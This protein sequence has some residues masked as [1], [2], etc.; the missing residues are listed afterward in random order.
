M[1]E[2]HLTFAPADHQRLAQLLDRTSQAFVRIDPEQRIVHVNRA[3]EK[4]LGYPPGALDGMTI[5]S[6]TPGIWR[7]STHNAIER[8]QATG[9]PQRYEKEYTHLDGHAVPV[10][11]IADFD[12]DDQEHVRGYYAFATDISE[13]KRIEDA[14]VA[15]E[16]RLRV[17]FEGISDAVFVH[18][19]EGRILDVNPAASRMLGYSRDEFRQLNTRD[20]DAPE[21]AEGFEERLRT[22]LRL[23][24][25]WCEG[26][27]RTR[28]GRI[29]PVEINTST[30]QL[31]NRTA[32]LA[33]IRD[34]S[35]RKNLEET[36]LRFAESQQQYA[37]Q[38]ETKAAELARS[39][40]HHRQ[41]TESLLDA[42]VVTDADA[43]ITLFNRAAEAV[44]GYDAQAVLGQPLEL[45][46]PKD[47]M[48]CPV[49]DLPQTLRESDPKVVGHT[50]EIQ[51]RRQSGEPVPLEISVAVIDLESNREFVASIRDLTERHRM[52]AM[53]L[54]SEKLASIG[55]LSA[56][57]AHEINNPL[58]YVANNLAVLQRDVGSLI[59]MVDALETAAVAP[60][61]EAQAAALHDAHRAA[62]D[63]DWPYVREH[64]PP[65]IQRTREGVQRVADIVANLRGLARTGPTRFELL[66]LSDLIDTALEMAQS[67][68][69][70]SNIEVRLD[71]PDLPKIPGV[72]AQISQVFLNFLVNAVQAIEQT[73]R[74]ID[75]RITIRLSEVG[76]FQVF[77]IEDNGVGI[78]PDAL[79][80][81]FDPFYTTKPV[82]EGTGLGLAI[83]HGI[84]TGHGG[85][86]QVESRAGQG[87][88]FRVLLPNT[89]PNLAA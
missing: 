73:K 66:S 16:R 84:I 41:L 57:V 77:E 39:E 88:T 31:E 36:R 52:R 85:S 83:S 63:L 24:H 40:A 79:A 53:L 80:R 71:R 38:L 32:V 48:G 87:T 43:R 49:S 59:P 89:N 60:N 46:L 55:L 34:I 12:R 5:D 30:V 76:G 9:E 68:M 86:I 28:D 70:H 13:R 8:L 47:P 14:L 61:R 58:A 54:Q 7:N 65:L 69:A 22:Q 17:L 18:D 45:L 75:N 72:A 27:H 37:Q 11:V 29:L 50:S 20:I 78:E 10:V 23:G 74:P 2:N 35:E 33:V 19:L 25:L 4:M 62:D 56:G 67:R 21:F 6:I 64:L 82:G 81:I 26:R 1:S 3:F 42:L 51:G 44:F 15:S